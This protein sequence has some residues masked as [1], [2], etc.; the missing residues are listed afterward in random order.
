MDIPQVYTVV[1]RIDP[2]QPPYHKNRTEQNSQCSTVLAVDNNC[3]D[4][5]LNST[6]VNYAY[7]Y[8]YDYDPRGR[9]MW[10]NYF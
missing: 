2:G 4:N 10:E 7:A 9:I 1:D 5:Q 6:Q 8:D 3:R